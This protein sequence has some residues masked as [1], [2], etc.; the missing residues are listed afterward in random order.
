M[1]SHNLYAL[2]RNAFGKHLERTA[3]QTDE[4]ARYRFADLDQQSSRMA[5]WLESLGV[6]PGDRVVVQVEKSVPALIFYLACLRAGV[7][8]VPHNTAYQSA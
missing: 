1:P 4:G 6:A 2:F 5:C 7:V 8:Y 3:I